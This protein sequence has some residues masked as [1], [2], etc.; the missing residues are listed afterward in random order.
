VK[1]SILKLYHEITTKAIMDKLDLGGL[2]E[3]VQ[4]VVA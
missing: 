1:Y 3:Q 2:K 4:Q